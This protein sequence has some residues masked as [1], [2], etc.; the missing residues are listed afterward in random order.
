MVSSALLY[1]Y[2]N[3]MAAFSANLVEGPP[4]TCQV[5]LL[6]HS[7]YGRDDYTKSCTKSWCA[8]WPPA[9]LSFDLIIFPWPKGRFTH[10]Q[11]RDHETLK[12]FGN[13]SKVV[14][15]STEIQFMGPQA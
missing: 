14:P 4:S 9:S 15:W 12:G 8:T 11:N 2:S 10:N 13:H 5:G 3:M 6:V 7:N 1:D